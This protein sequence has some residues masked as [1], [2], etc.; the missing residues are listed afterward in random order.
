MAGATL[1]RGWPHCI[2]GSSQPRPHWR[3]GRRRKLRRYRRRWRGSPVAC[4]ARRTGHHV[5]ECPHGVVELSVGLVPVPAPLN[6]AVDGKVFNVVVAHSRRRWGSRP[7]RKQWR[8]VRGEPYWGQAMLRSHA[9][10]LSSGRQSSTTFRALRPTPCTH[11]R[12]VF[13]MPHDIADALVSLRARCCE[14]NETACH[15]ASTV[16]GL[17]RT[18]GHA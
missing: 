2:D 3:M 16:A 14:T 12:L 13:S 11:E 8:S 1:R 9:S 7:G 5:F 10:D 17:V 15:G 18:R 4:G 6:V